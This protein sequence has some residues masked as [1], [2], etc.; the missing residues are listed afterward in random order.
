VRRQPIQRL[1]LLYQFPVGPTTQRMTS[2]VNQPD[3][4]RYRLESSSDCQVSG[5]E[6]AHTIMD[7]QRLCAI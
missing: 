7:Q 2:L 5:R 3:D 6:G 4:D 1:G